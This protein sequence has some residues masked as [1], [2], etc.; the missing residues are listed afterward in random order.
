M[1]Q[2]GW[3]IVTEELSNTPNSKL[4]GQGVLNHCW[5]IEAVFK[6]DKIY[7]ESQREPTGDY[8]EQELIAYL[9]FTKRE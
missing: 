3:K 9:K 6:Q 2:S 4:K 5:W 8:R 1:R 7:N